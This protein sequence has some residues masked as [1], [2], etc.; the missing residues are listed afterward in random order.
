MII[1]MTIQNFHYKKKKAQ[2]TVPHCF[3]TIYGNPTSELASSAEN[4]IVAMK[5]VENNYKQFRQYNMQ[6]KLLKIFLQHDKY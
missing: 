5:R 3:Y 4:N 1:H 6:Q 2:I